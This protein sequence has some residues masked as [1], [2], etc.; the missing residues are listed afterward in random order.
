MVLLF[1]VFLFS[2]SHSH[3]VQA[4]VYLWETKPNRITPCFL[5]WMSIQHDTDM[6][7]IKLVFGQWFILLQYLTTKPTITISHIYPWEKLLPA[8][9]NSFNQSLT[10][11]YKLKIQDFEE[12]TGSRK[13]EFLIQSTNIQWKAE[14]K[15]SAKKRANIRIYF[16][17]TP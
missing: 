3:V 17:F 6:L 8:F 4:L 11:G 1:S 16:S 5:Q 10:G 14:S 15:L 12:K 13:E 7:L 2:V 9:F